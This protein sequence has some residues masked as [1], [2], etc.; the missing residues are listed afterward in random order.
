MGGVKIKKKGVKKKGLLFK[1][2]GKGVKIKKKK[3]ALLFSKIKK[4][5][6]SPSIIHVFGDSKYIFSKV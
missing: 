1:K 5:G 3:E 2:D 6:Q 4:N